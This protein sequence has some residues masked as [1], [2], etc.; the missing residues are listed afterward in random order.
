MSDKKH[1][2]YIC[3]SCG[4][5]PKAAQHKRPDGE[6]CGY[7]AFW[8]DSPLKKENYDLKARITKLENALLEAADDIENNTYHDADGGFDCRYEANNYRAIAKGEK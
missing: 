4:A 3:T 2:S 8:V 7:A 5:M 1:G 6:D